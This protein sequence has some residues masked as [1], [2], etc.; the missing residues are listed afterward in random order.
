MTCAQVTRTSVT[1]TPIANLIVTGDGPALKDNFTLDNRTLT[2]RELAN[3]ICDTLQGHGYQAL[4]VGGCVRDLLLG[5]QPVSP[6]EP[7]ARNGSRKA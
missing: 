5:R 3:S 1:R 6:A 7:S 2:P 4:L